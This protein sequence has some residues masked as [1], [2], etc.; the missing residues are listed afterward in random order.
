MR[1]IKFRGKAINGDWVYGLLTKKKIRSSGE[2]SYAIATGDCSLSNTVPVVEET[3]GEFT[4]LKDKSGEEIYEGDILQPSDGSRLEVQYLPGGWTCN[5][6]NANMAT[7]IGNIFEG[8][9]NER[10]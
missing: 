10:N 4:G 8:D 7:V 2:I 1:E 3:I 9:F 5:S 6:I